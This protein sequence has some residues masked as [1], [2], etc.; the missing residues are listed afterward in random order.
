[1][2]STTVL[3]L[4]AVA[5]T[6]VT[7]MCAASAETPA[8]AIVTNIAQL[9]STIAGAEQTTTSNPVS[10][11]V[12]ERL[13][14]TL[15]R[16][17]QGAVQV[18]PGGVAVPFLL[19]NAGNGREAFALAARIDDP[20]ATVRLIAIDADGDGRFDPA[21]ET[22]IVDGRTPVLAPGASLALLVVVDPAGSP[23]TATSLSLAASA[24][25][26]SGA[27]GT[28]FASRGDGGGDAVTGATGAAAIATAPL[29]SAADA[30]TLTK[31]QSV[32]APDGS[33][34]AVPD[35]VVTYSLVARFPGPAN[36]ARIADPIPA[37][38]RYVPGSLTLDGAPLSDAA[39]ADAGAVD[40]D[41][42]AVA[43]GDVAAP[44]ART[45]T[46]QVTI[47]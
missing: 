6:C 16:A 19:R 4:A 28:V 18:P 23:V 10:L 34:S 2:A 32:R 1:M 27:P 40:V 42:V 17:T 3:C 38:T 30:P 11:T 14:V 22:P 46:F 5:M 44:A 31:S 7:P 29:D 33:A 24:V 39:D 20:S 45:V 47:Q 8:G 43:L 25:T 37:G 35:A 36:A 15:A 21:S 41:G 26:G 12:A 9:R 13:D